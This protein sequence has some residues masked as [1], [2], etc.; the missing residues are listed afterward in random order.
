MPMAGA[1]RTRNILIASQTASTS[2]Q[3]ISTNSTGSRV[4]SIIRR[5]PSGPPIQWSVFM[6]KNVVVG[7]AKILANAVILSAAKN[8]R[9]SSEI[10]RCAQNDKKSPHPIG[11]TRA[12]S[13]GGPR[14]S[15]TFSASLRLNAAYFSCKA[16][17][18]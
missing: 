7:M 16:E 8:L 17:V 11:V 12:S 15:R 10:L 5:W 3:S 9:N 18:G 14:P 13:F 4:W 2:R 1:P 6:E